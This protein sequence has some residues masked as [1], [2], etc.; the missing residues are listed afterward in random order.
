MAVEQASNNPLETYYFDAHVRQSSAKW[1]KDYWLP[2][3][4]RNIRLL[5]SEQD[6]SEKEVA[7]AR[8]LVYNEMKREISAWDQL[9][10]ENCLDDIKNGAT[11]SDFK[12]VNN[13]LEILEAAWRVKVNKR[14][15]E[16]QDIIDDIEDVIIKQVPEVYKIFIETHQ[17]GKVEELQRDKVES[18]TEKA[19][20]TRK[21]VFRNSK[22]KIENEAIGEE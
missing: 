19:S 16:V 6:L 3:I 14:S 7:F 5:Y 18:G 1:K 15:A 20:K 2:E 17:M 11:E 12:E 21:T 9:S 8:E 10:C 4:R 22:R 13:Y